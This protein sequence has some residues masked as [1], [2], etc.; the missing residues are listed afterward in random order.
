MSD[1]K[2]NQEF[3][4]VQI[5]YYFHSNHTEELN[6]YAEK[7]LADSGCNCYSYGNVSDSEVLLEDLKTEFPNG[8]KFPYID[9]ANAILAMSCPKPIKRAPWRMVWE[10]EHTVDSIDCDSE[11]EAKTRAM[12]TL[13]G[14]QADFVSHILFFTKLED[15]TDKQKEDWN[16]MIYN[17]SVSVRKYNINTDEYEG[18]WHPSQEEEKEINWVVIV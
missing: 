15:M 12:D 6:E 7:I 8:M 4:T 2:Q 14:W 16:N 11:E 18:Y 1:A 5:D 10:T 3:D 17:C 13:V 9:V